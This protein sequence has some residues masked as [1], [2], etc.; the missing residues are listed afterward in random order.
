MKGGS[1]IS[2]LRASSA[3]YLLTEACC[4]RGVSDPGTVALAAA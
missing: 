1:Q 4:V 2:L 3:T